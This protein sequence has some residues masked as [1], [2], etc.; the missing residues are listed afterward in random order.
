[1]VTDTNAHSTAGAEATSRRETLHP[2][3]A[4]T[5]LLRG[6]LRTDK[7]AVCQYNKKKHNL[8]S[9]TSDIG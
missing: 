6:W 4:P 1:M 7:Y 3:T 2:P 5:K 8:A 9:K